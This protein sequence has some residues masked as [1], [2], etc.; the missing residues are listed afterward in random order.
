[1]EDL[2]KSSSVLYTSANM[3]EGREPLPTL[4]YFPFNILDIDISEEA[5]N[6]QQGEFSCILGYKAPNF[7]ISDGWELYSL[8]VS[9]YKHRPLSSHTVLG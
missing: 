9:S 2:Q 5:E 6:E 8:P 3:E 7:W 1:M 4:W